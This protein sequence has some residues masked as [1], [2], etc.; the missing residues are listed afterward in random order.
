VLSSDPDAADDPAVRNSHD[1]RRLLGH[2]APEPLAV[3]PRAPRD[4]LRCDVP[5]LLRDLADDV[6]ELGCVARACRPDL[7]TFRSLGL[8]FGGLV[9]VEPVEVRD[10]LTT[11]PERR[12]AVADAD[13]GW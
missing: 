8:R 10:V 11:Q 7:D 6:D 5:A 2:R 9:H 1:R 3:R 12:T 4:L 13:H